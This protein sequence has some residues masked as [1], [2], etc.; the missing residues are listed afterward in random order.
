MKTL[1]LNYNH[2]INKWYRVVYGLEED[3]MPSDTCRLGW[4]YIFLLPFTFLFSPSYIREWILGTKEDNTHVFIRFLS[5]VIIAFLTFVI[6]FACVFIGISFRY[7][8][9]ELECVE[10][11][12]LDTFVSL[13]IGIGIAI[14]VISALGALI[15]IIIKIVE[16][17]DDRKYYRKYVKQ[18]EKEPGFIKTWLRNKKEKS[19]SKIEWVKPEQEDED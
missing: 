1:E 19:C 16:Y 9:E 5:S 14:A 12:S 2:W 18:E 13:F 4:G 17:Y 10:L 3:N 15:Y 11:F 7:S 6:L 8:K